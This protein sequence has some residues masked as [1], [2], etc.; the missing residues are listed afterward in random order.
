MATQT[1]IWT[2]LPN[3]IATT[4]GGDVI[5]RLSVYV[6]FRLE[7]NASEG[8]TL[9]VYPDILFWTTTL[10]NIRS[11]RLEFD[12]PNQ[13]A[14]PTLLSQVNP[15]WWHSLFDERTFV[16]PYTLPDYT[17]RLIVSYPVTNIVNFVKHL[18]QQVGL[19]NPNE[20]P[21][22]L[23]RG[24]RERK[25]GGYLFDNEGF[26]WNKDVA[27]GVR[28]RLAAEF[29]HSGGVLNNN[30]LISEYDHLVAFQNGTDD[31]RP[32]LQ[33]LLLFHYPPEK[34]N[35]TDSEDQA[36]VTKPLP[37][38]P[39]NEA[40]FERYMDFH[41]VV[42]SLGDYPVLMRQLGLVLDFAVPLDQ[43]PPN[44]QTVRVIPQWNANAGIN[45]VSETPWTALSFAAASDT[46][47]TRSRGSGMPQVIENQLRID[48]PGDGFELVEIDVDGT[49][50]K[51]IGL[52][53]SVM[54]STRLLAADTPSQGG[55]PS[56]R[57][58]GLSLNL[59]G[60]AV[61]THDHF[62]R[63]VDN[64]QVNKSDL[65]L[66]AEDV[67]RGYRVDIWDTMTATWHS[68]CQRVGSY[69][70]EGTDLHLDDVIDEG[71]AQMAMTE[72]APP[73][74]G[75]PPKSTDLYLHESIFR[76]DGWSLVAPRPGK[77]IGQEGDGNSPLSD[78]QPQPMMPF[79]LVTQFKAAPHTLPRLRFGAS[80]RIRVRVA[81]L[82]GNSPALEEAGD[83]HALPPT[84]QPPR[85]YLRF[86]PVGSP[87]AYLRE[88]IAAADAGESLAR[89]VIRSYNSSPDQDTVLS[90]EVAERHIAPPPASEQILEAHGILDDLAGKLRNEPATYALISSRSQPVDPDTTDSP[91]FPAEQMDITYLPDPLAAGAALRNLPATPEGTVGTVDA[92]GAVVYTSVE[93]IE[94]RPGSVLQIP[95]GGAPTDDPLADLLG[96]QAFRLV[97][98]EP[99]SGEFT[100]PEWDNN[101]R[102]L[103]LSLPKTE[104]I[105][106]ALSSYVLR[107]QLKLMGV[108]DWIREFI[109]LS[110]QANLGSPD[111][112]AQLST[113]VVNCVQYALEGGHW[114][115]TPS[116][117]LTLVHPVQQPIGFPEILVLSAA[118]NR[119]DTS[120]TFI[121]VIQIHGKST[122]NINLIAKWEEPIDDPSAP[123][124]P[125]VRSVEQQVDDVIL[126]SLTGGV[127]PGTKTD[128]NGF[129]KMVGAYDPI[130]DWLEFGV[131]TSPAHEFGDTKHRMIHYSVIAGSR[132]REYFAADAAGGFTRPS[133]PMLVNVPSSAR[134]AP[135]S[136]RY[137]LP[138]YGWKREA[139]TNLIGSYRQGGGLRVYLDRGWYS[140]GE[141]E[142]LG[143]VL[144][145]GYTLDNDQRHALTRYITQWGMDPIWKS[146]PTPDMPSTYNFRDYETLGYSLLLPELAH[147]G[148]P[149]DNKVNVVG[150]PVYYDEA[151]SLWYCDIDLDPGASYYPFI[152]L[153]LARYQPSS[154]TGMHLSRVT[155]ADFAQLA[156]DRSAILTYDPFDTD[157]LNLV[158]SGFTYTASAD[159]AG[160]PVPD[161]SKFVVSVER[162]DPDLSDEL[163]W[164]PASGV[165]I[166]PE[167]VGTLDRVLW[168][169]HIRLPADHQPGEYRV[170]VEEYEQISQRFDLST[171]RIIGRINRGNLELDR[172]LLA[173]AVGLRI[174]RRPQVLRAAR[175]V[176]AD[177]IEL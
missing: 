44:A 3:G 61:Y 41:Q 46:F 31:P 144:W 50:L 7:A 56:I 58:G 140:S 26:P 18:Y 5:A 21:D 39:Q 33:R 118:R 137:V 47:R 177:T 72:Q 171:L 54:A 69:V 70:I 142:L 30:A 168:K 121:S 19:S 20:L 10:R 15:H 68:L 96:E 63:V 156:P 149:S 75:A 134:P 73:A 108:W 60:R 88:A 141:G 29:F 104:E 159:T 23:G 84:S 25:L 138:T 94:I 169:G 99:P 83:E 45:V 4:E 48:P 139:T 40:D 166:T 62:Q 163:A 129:L 160:I 53:N 37:P 154:I 111:V 6:S 93:G 64:D 71:F 59:T 132:F 79:K 102:T 1:I 113:M 119:G 172:P 80:Y 151:R 12:N 131:N 112:L 115:L 52:S 123:G 65:V 107:D 136:V 100:A 165:V 124:G 55:L 77:T 127:I 98:V 152:R 176:Y 97:V 103:T 36:N 11:F 109:D 143:V 49:A 2:A 38:L 146:S 133:Q 110:I 130:R 116:R 43:I 135:P 14:T 35:T 122:L 95:Y 90:G 34:L 105:S 16:R 162:R 17:D 66:Y 32:G 86:E 13:I 155:L 106:F 157:V 85:T 24:Q 76:W 161:A 27:A 42:S 91:V 175:L 57:S 117:T 9:S 174:L 164:S 89:L 92:G 158:V 81:D 167:Q 153:A 150:Y 74:E 128:K 78:P 173:R 148:V 120:A 125:E 8:D 114:M 87:S 82:A 28:R 51:L 145:Q 22:L 147:T 101:A 126:R 67:L 170:V